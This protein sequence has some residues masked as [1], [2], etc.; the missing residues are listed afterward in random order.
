MK[1]NPD[2]IRDILLTVEEVTDF[3][4]R[5]V[6][7][8]SDNQFSKL[9]KYT[10]QEIIYHIRQAEESDLIMGVSYPDSGEM[11]IICDLSPFGHEFLANIRKDNIWNNIKS[12]S[13][14]IGS[15]SLNALVQISSNVITEIIK[16]QFN[17]NA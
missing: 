14:Q 5:L 9:Q 6:Y 4:T 13:K 17:L 1:L 16:A 11:C 15:T 10:H 8:M 2:C 3:D 7:I 12:I